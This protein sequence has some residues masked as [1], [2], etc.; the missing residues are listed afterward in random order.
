MQ[1]ARPAVAGPVPVDF[2]VAGSDVCAGRLF[3]PKMG[4]VIGKL[5]LAQREAQ[6]ASAR[7]LGNHQMGT[8]AAGSRRGDLCH[9]LRVT[10]GW[11]YQADLRA[12]APA[13]G[14]YG[15]P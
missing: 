1:G 15:S 4:D 10:A 5:S 14:I 13:I 6:G 2:Y 8:V 11:V 9:A 3:L 7:V 12:S